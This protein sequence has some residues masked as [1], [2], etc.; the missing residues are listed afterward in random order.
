MVSFSEFE[1]VIKNVYMNNQEHVFQYWNELNDSERRTLVEEL[2]SIDFNLMNGLYG[3][4]DLASADTSEFEPAEYISLPDSREQNNNINSAKAAG[5]EHI[6]KGNTAV[7]LVAGGQGTRL[8]FNGPKGMFPIGAVS[9]KS[10]F[11]IHAEKI[12]FIS[13]KYNISIPWLV[14]TSKENNTDTINYFET[15]NYFGLKNEDV[16]FF[17]QNMLPSLDVNG[18]LLLKTKNSIIINPDGHGGVLSALSTS[19]LLN[20]LRN[21]NINTIFYFQVDN[22]LVNILDPVFIGFHVQNNSDVSSKAIMKI[23]ADEKVGVFVKFNNGKTGIIEY[24]DLP[25]EKQGVV[26]NKGKLLYCMGNIAVHCFKL[27]FIESLVSRTDLSLP[28]HTARKKIIALLDGEEKEINSLKF[29]KFIFDSIT[30]TGKNTILETRREDEFAPVKNADGTD[31]PG[32]AKELMNNLYRKWTLNRKIIVPGIVKEM[33]IS[34]LLAAE[35][36]DLPENII[37]PE[38]EKVYLE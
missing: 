35:P 1:N 29:E 5:A 13:K 25:K 38:Q 4:K 22:P 9:G 33:E 32:S 12:L 37:I 8:G 16:I 2:S 26:D 18:K 19:G 23:S 6:S 17:S 10:L 27:S 34:P 11:R 21:R 28:F 14:M 7:L 31:S 24:S 30:L 20:E 36:D 15:N 3:Q